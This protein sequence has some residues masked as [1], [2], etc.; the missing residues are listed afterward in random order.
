[1]YGAFLRPSCT[2]PAARWPGALLLVALV[3][4]VC[5]AEVLRADEGSVPGVIHFC[6]TNCFT[7]RFDQGIYRRTDGTEETWSVERF[8]SKSV[9][10]RRH[11]PPAGWNGFS[12][13]V[14]YQGQV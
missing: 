7:L 13:D 1:M 10:L 3:L 12:A 11:D 9:I 4:L 14:T 5:P 6:W 8:S 2:V